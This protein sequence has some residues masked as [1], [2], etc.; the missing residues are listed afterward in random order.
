MKLDQFKSSLS[1]SEPPDGLTPALQALWWDGK[2]DWAKAHGCV[3]DEPGEVAAWVHA[4][5][6]RKEGDLGNAGYWYGQAG[7]PVA[8]VSL[9]AEWAAITA[10]LLKQEGA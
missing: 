1:Q 10:S 5:L 6:H 8:K 7:K 3:D 9:E 2:G 4:Y